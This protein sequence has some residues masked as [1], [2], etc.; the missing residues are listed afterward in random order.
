MRAN[1]G[2]RLNYCQ[3]HDCRNGAEINGR[4]IQ[5]MGFSGGTGLC[6]LLKWN[7]AITNGTQRDARRRKNDNNVGTNK[8]GS[9]KAACNLLKKL[10]A[11]DG[12]EPPTHGFSVR[13][14]TN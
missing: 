2:L 13:C 11:R 12:I 6:R 3:A 4:F 10:M 5:S 14:S 1:N 9:V 8:K 7:A